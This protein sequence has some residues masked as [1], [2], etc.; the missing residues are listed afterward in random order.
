MVQSRLVVLDSFVP[1][2]AVG[3]GDFVEGAA[4]YT[5]T[6]QGFVEGAAR[7]THRTRVRLG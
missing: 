6:L 3:L 5:V 7:Y 4:R 2:P 1:L